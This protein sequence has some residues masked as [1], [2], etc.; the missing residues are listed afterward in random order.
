MMVLA[1]RLMY[2]HPDDHTI[3]TTD[4]HGFKPFLLAEKIS[5]VFMQDLVMGC[6]SHLAEHTYSCMHIHLSLF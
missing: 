4:T 2:P 6:E 1:E 3:R 5:P